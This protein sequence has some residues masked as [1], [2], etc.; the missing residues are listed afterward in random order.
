MFNS[1]HT[2]LFTRCRFKRRIF[3]VS[4]QVLD[5]NLAKNLKISRKPKKIVKVCL[6]SL[7]FDEFFK[8][9]DKTFQKSDFAQ[10]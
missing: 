3:K 9:F 4:K 1:L 7:Q 8:F 6:H 2:V 10:I 5:R